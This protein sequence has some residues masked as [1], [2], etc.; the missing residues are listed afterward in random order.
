M[1]DEDRFLK[2]TLTPNHLVPIV[3]TDDTQEGSNNEPRFVSLAADKLQLGMR[4]ITVDSTSSETTSNTHSLVTPKSNN[5]NVIQH[6]TIVNISRASSY[7]SKLYA[8]HTLPN[9]MV[10]DGIVVSCSTNGMFL[11]S[12]H[13]GE[14][15]PVSQPAADA[16]F[17]MLLA[18]VHFVVH[19]GAVIS[20][21]LLGVSSS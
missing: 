8:P 7:G 6:G 12:V 20:S 3:M 9:N 17:Q 5:N 2:L 1:E 21:L 10:I 19:Y 11:Q 13:S 15:S 14:G 4:L 18:P 16:I